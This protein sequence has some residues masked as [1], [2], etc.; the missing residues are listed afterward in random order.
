MA[1]L[2]SSLLG[3][4]A[5]SIGCP[6][7]TISLSP[8]ALIAGIYNGFIG[9]DYLSIMIIMAI[10]IV[11]FIVL[12]Y[13]SLFAF[14]F[15]LFGYLIEIAPI[16]ISLLSLFT[17]FML[18]LVSSS[19]SNLSLIILFIG[20]EGIG[21]VSYLLI[22]YWSSRLSGSAAS[23]KAFLINRFGD[24][25]L[26]LAIALIVDLDIP[27]I[28]LIPNL[29]GDYLALIGLFILFSIMAKSAL[30]PI[31]IW[32]PY[33]M[34]GPTP[35]SALLHAATLVIAGIYLLLRFYRLFSSSALIVWIGAI[36]ALIGSV[37]ANIFND[38]KALIAYSTI[39]HLG[40]MVMASGIGL[41]SLALAN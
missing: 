26:I 29:N 39:S 36:T 8:L 9:L 30:F 17:F 5:G 33:S 40:F 13:S 4:K 25:G 12:K 22:G 16:F 35:V 15:A 1:F 14:L 27:F 10:S 32:L 20:W 19:A 37:Y 28:A 3:R 23:L 18:L 24:L 11:S 7:M 31:H 21:L 6:L 41:Y 38:L 34:E 2:V